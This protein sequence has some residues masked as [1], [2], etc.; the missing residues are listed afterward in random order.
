MYEDLLSCGSETNYDSGNHA[1]YENE[2]VVHESSKM[3]KFTG[4][5][6]RWYEC[7]D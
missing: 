1:N 4:S 7:R 2:V 3:Q 6:D 5:V